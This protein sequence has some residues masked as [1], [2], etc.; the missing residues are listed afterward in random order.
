MIG[1]NSSGARL[2]A[3][4][5]IRPAWQLPITAGAPSASGWASLTARMNASTAWNTSSR[6][7]PGTGSGV[8]PTKYVG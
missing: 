1:P 5:T 7:W 2:A 8:K 3:I 6:V 4:I